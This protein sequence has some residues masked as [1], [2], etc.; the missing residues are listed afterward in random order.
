MISVIGKPKEPISA[1]RGW[2][3]EHFFAAEKIRAG[4]PA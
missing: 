3:S 1:I 4:G 2:G